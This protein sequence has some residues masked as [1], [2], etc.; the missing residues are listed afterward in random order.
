MYIK[1]KKLTGKVNFELRMNTSM[2]TEQCGLGKPQT[3]GRAQWI[4]VASV[5]SIWFALGRAPH[6]G[7]IQGGVK[8][9]SEIILRPIIFLCGPDIVC[10]RT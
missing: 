8:S 9:L 5:H 3:G 2:T 6:G 1:K 7:G 4:K 10:V